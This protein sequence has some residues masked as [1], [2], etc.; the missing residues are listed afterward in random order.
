MRRATKAALKLISKAMVF[1]TVGLRV[2]ATAKVCALGVCGTKRHHGEDVDC[3]SVT[4]RPPLPEEALVVRL[5][6]LGRVNGHA[7]W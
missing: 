2:A 4:W 3:R 1:L 5:G 6:R 7:L